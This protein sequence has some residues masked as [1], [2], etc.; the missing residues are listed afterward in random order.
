M[1][2][3]MSLDERGRTLL[4]RY[5]WKSGFRQINSG[6]MSSQ[7]TGG[8]EGIES[9]ETERRGISDAL[10]VQRNDRQRTNHL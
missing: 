1:S 4:V 9:N 8:R 2:L 3:F 5:S 10:K 6:V 7:M